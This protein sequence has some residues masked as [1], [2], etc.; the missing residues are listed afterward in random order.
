MRSRPLNG[1]S[2]V[3]VLAVALIVVPLVV[4]AFGA[5][6]AV[7]VRSLVATAVSFRAVVFVALRALVTVDAFAFAVALAVAVFFLFALFAPSLPCAVC[8][9]RSRSLGCAAEKKIVW[10]NFYS[11]LERLQPNKQ[12]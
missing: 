6:E 12:T 2:V 4:H 10:N 1:T 11:V 5:A 9:Q 7:A 8:A 3:V